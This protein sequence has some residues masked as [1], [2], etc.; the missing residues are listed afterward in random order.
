MNSS[1]P[2]VLP[3]TD[4]G[5]SIAD[6]RLFL[7]G[8]RG[9]GKTT[10]G[11]CLSNALGWKTADTDAM[12]VKRAGQSIEAIFQRHGEPEFRKLET[13][14]IKQVCDQP[15]PLIISLG[16]GAPVSSDNVKLIRNAGRSVWLRAKVET[17]WQRIQSDP[18]TGE[19]RPD[20]TDT[21]GQQEVEK[22]LEW[23]T[24]I[25]QSASDWVVDVDDKSEHIV[26]NEIMNWLGQR[27]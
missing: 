13:E 17:L 7:I 23:R 8:Y 4:Q 14:A 10:V 19:Q 16:G 12:I 11:E 21:G 6:V 3:S 27:S 9:S 25:Y 5:H 15:E 22:V 1:D 26:T 20:L 2:P 18:K 24:P